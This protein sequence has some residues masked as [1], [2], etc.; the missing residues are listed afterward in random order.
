MA[1][2]DIL[3]LANNRL[4]CRCRGAIEGC[5]GDAI[6]ARFKELTEPPAPVDEVAPLCVALREAFSEL[7]GQGEDPTDEEDS[8]WDRGDSF[9]EFSAREATNA[10]E[11]PRGRAVGELC[12]QRDKDEVI[13]DMPEDGL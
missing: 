12:V 3:A 7:S 1:R 10:A 13:P 8:S 2:E 6:I 11:C 4:A 5:H 9:T